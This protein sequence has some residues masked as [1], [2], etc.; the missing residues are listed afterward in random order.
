M[1]WS[2]RFSPWNTL[3]SGFQSQQNEKNSGKKFQVR[4]WAKFFLRCYDTVGLM[5]TQKRDK[6]IFTFYCPK[7][8]F[9]KSYLCPTELNIRHAEWKKDVTV[10]LLNFN[11][12]RSKYINLVFELHTE[13]TCLW[14]IMQ[15]CH[16]V[17]LLVLVST[18]D[19][20]SL[21]FNPV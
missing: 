1:A 6:T 20:T 16:E 2:K 17:S 21:T 5:Q 13:V 8:V 15:R 11:I 10:R 12:N 7:S 19:D 14:N 3:I 9:Q 4:I 18:C